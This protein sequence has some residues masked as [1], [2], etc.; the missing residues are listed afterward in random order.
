LHLSG[1]GGGKQSKPSYKVVL[2]E[3]TRKRRRGYVWNFLFLHMYNVEF[4]FYISLYEGQKKSDWIYWILLDYNS[5]S[6]TSHHS[7]LQTPEHGFPAIY[8]CLRSWLVWGKLYVFIQFQCKIQMCFYLKSWHVWGKIC[9]FILFNIKYICGVCELN[10]VVSFISLYVTYIR[11]F[12]WYIRHDISPLPKFLL[13]ITYSFPCL[14][15]MREPRTWMKT[16]LQQKWNFNAKKKLH[17]HTHTYICHI[18]TKR[19][20]L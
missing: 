1:F 13:R 8:V 5:S 12:H 14:I 6:L 15:I 3:T 16:K 20:N 2:L 7:S 9:G 11:I 10:F 18:H 19:E 4:S 17:T